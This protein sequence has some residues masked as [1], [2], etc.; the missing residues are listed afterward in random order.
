MLLLEMGIYKIVIGLATI[1]RKIIMM[2]DLTRGYFANHKLY[3]EY[4]N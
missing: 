1:T 4:D 2:R 3:G